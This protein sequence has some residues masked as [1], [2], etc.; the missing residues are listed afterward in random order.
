MEA[1]N[2]Y[3]LSLRDLRRA[4]PSGALL[5]LLL[6]APARAQEA[7]GPQYSILGM[8]GSGLVDAEVGVSVGGGSSVVVKH[9]MGR[10][11]VDAHL[12]ASHDIPYAWHLT[13]ASPEC[14]NEGTGQVVDG[15]Q[16]S[17]ASVLFGISGEVGATAAVGRGEISAAGG[18]RAGPGSTPYAALGYG[19]DPAGRGWRL[20]LRGVAGRNLLRLEGVVT[21]S[22]GSG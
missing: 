12:V 20:L 22:L 10:V 19:F 15:S 2:G 18:Y 8:L 5:A 9:L 7:S 13:S 6:A 14:R 3:R 11:F 1:A 21:V 4:L 17:I 16:C